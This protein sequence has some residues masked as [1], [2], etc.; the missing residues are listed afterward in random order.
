MEGGFLRQQA[1][2]A[3]AVLV[4]AA[5][6]APPTAPAEP[7]TFVLSGIVTASAPSHAPLAEVKLTVVDG[8]GAGQSTTTDH[9]GQFALTA[10]KG[11]IS[12]HAS[13]DG[14]ESQTMTV[15]LTGA[16]SVRFTL[17]PL[18][19]VL[20]LRLTPEMGA[21]GPCDQPCRLY[22]LDVHNDGVIAAAVTWRDFGF[23]LNVS[24]W[25]G[26]ARI[27]TSRRFNTLA[28]GFTEVPVAGGFTYQLRVTADERPLP[29][30]EVGLRRPN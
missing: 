9:N 21:P 1:L 22:T 10:A 5:C 30:F 19:V 6:G 8:A 11:P 26:D 3:L 23:Y 20:Q 25:R 7:T 2:L 24:L 12:L 4:T 13:R 29:N 16:E 28:N 14:Y 15:D 18:P 27:A 17:K